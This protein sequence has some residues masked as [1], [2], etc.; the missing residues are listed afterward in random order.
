[1]SSTSA[2]DSFSAM[3]DE[4]QF[5]GD[6]YIISR[7]GKPAAA[8]VPMD[9]YEAWKRNRQRFFQLVRDFQE[10]SGDN[11]PDE[12]MELVLEAQ[13]AIRSEVADETPSQP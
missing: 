3:L 12:I 13:Q 8:L 9:V 11:D 4:V 2:R 1:M 10:G 6:Q 7:K 5:Q